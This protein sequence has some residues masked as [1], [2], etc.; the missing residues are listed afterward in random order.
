M[1]SLISPIGSGFDTFC[2]ISTVNAFVQRH[3]SNGLSFFIYKV[4]GET[5]YAVF[6]FDEQK[7]SFQ[8][9]YDEICRLIKDNFG[10]GLTKEDPVEI[11][12]HHFKELFVE[13]K[14][15][16]H[17]QSSVMRIVD[18]AHLWTYYLNSDEEKSGTVYG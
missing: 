17:I 8:S 6:A 16:D 9:A 11:T 3:A 13:A 10:I 7:N 2:G 14:R 12:M 18:M 4:E 5:A 1:A 15:H